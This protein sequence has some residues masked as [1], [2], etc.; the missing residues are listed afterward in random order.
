MIL[1]EVFMRKFRTLIALGLLSATIFAQDLMKPSAAL[2]DNAPADA[3]ALPA[4]A[5]TTTT[6]SSSPANAPS[7]KD[8]TDLLIDRIIGREHF[9]MESMSHL[10]PMLET[11]VQ[12]MKPD[13][14]LGL[15]PASDEYFLGRLDFGKK[16][17]SEKLFVDEPAMWKKV[18]KALNPAMPITYVPRGFISTMLIDGEHFDRAHYDLTY[19]R[20]EFLGDVRCLVFDVTPTKKGGA[21]N[22][23]TGRIWVEDQE[24]NIVRT[25]GSHD[26]SA[27]SHQFHSDVWRQNLRPG[28]WLPTYVYS[29]ESDMK[30]GVVRKLR[31]KSQ[32]R[33]WGYDV[34]FNMPQE[35]LTRVLVDDPNAV[36]DHSEAAQD[37]GPVQSQRAWEIEAQENVLEKLEK[38]GLLAPKGEVD[39]VLETVVNNLM[40]TNSLDIQPEVH[41]RVLLTAPLESFT[42]GHT[43]VLSRGL[44]DV[45]PD[46]SSLAMALGHELAH[47][48]L[49]HR[50]DTKYAFNDRTMFP[51]EK[52]FHQVGLGLNE[53]DELAAD[54]RA[55]ELLQKS[56]YKDKLSG[57][58]LFLKALELRAGEIPNLLTPRL[59]SPMTRGNQVRM[60]ALMQNA[61]ELQMTRTEQIAALP[62]GGRVKMDPWTNAIEFSK[63][64]PVPLLHAREKMPFE[65]TPLMPYIHR[66]TESPVSETPASKQGASA[67]TLLPTN[68][69]KP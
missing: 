54:A 15:V 24:Y 59:G 46:E 66:V 36:R 47:I 31:F 25:K 61:P 64:K 68:V 27:F 18:L 38:A 28:L 50:L 60:A 22:P 35:E 1:N 16:E 6:T 2:K 40:I 11:Y 17:T 20:R 34:K 45:L 55:I 39:K 41:C 44:L 13:D 10:A 29:E 48:V 4:S 53:H 9:M 65:V 67:T 37:M 42:V 51:D 58:G 52:T 12:N 32:T 30:Y 33:L 14:E 49:G 21:S 63:N 62:L 23:Y 43:I 56:P 8:T 19:V 3:T 26:G 57:A 7:V 69:P 5:T